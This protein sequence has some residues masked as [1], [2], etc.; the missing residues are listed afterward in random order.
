MITQKLLHELF[1]YKDGDLYWKKKIGSRAIIGYK[2]G[3][4]DKEY[5]RARIQRKNYRI[6]RLIF[7]YHY[8]YLPEFIDHF[9]GNKLNNKIENLR[10]A[11]RSE[12]G[13]NKSIQINNKSGIKNVNWH[14]RDKKWMVQISVNGEKKHF[15]AYY[16]I[17]VA[18][19]IAETM[20]NKY[21]GNFANHG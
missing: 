17:E 15:G 11:T 6:H 13:W 4:L 16:D 3:T 20:R 21:H 19:F 10:E 14:K 8:G 12:N 18:K 2:L 9:D 5:I 7:L 1:E